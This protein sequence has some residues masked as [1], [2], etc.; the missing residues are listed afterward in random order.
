[1]A[2]STFLNIGK[3]DSGC[4]AKRKQPNLAKVQWNNT[5]TGLAHNQET[6]FAKQTQHWPSIQQNH[7]ILPTDYLPKALL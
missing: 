6:R 2:V 4:A 3:A 5:K 1:M 7:P